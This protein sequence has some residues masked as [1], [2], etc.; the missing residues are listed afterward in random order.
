MQNDAKLLPCPFCGGSADI[1]HDHTAEEN[2][3]YGCRECVL[4]FGS[5][6]SDDPIAAWN[7]R[8]PH[9]APVT[10]RE[11]GPVAWRYR[12][13]DNRPPCWDYMEGSRP[14]VPETAYEVQLLY[15]HPPQ[16]SEAVV[17]AL[18]LADDMFRDL[19]WHSKYEITSA[20]LRALSSGEASHD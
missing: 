12:A 4:W 17:E 3:E 6:N 18:Q 7:T 2:H 10:A 15:T 9:P 13:R 1:S 11:A 5:S 19:G 16:S 8:T 20:A 14:T